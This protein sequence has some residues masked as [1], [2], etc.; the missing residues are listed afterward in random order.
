MFKCCKNGP[1]SLVSSKNSKTSCSSTN[2]ALNAFNVFSLNK[3]QLLLNSPANSIRFQS[4]QVKLA[5]GKDAC[6]VNCYL[7]KKKIMSAQY[8][9][10]E[11]KLAK[12]LTA[13]QTCSFW[14]K[15]ISA[16][17]SECI[18]TVGAL[19]IPDFIWQNQNC[20]GNAFVVVQC[21][22]LR[23]I[24]SCPNTVSSISCITRYQL[25]N[26]CYPNILTQA[27]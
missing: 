11:T 5:F 20:P 6:F 27:I 16:A 21:V 13:R 17:A 10:D 7:M 8:V 24:H 25:F 14:K 19:D 4:Q 15:T 26:K 23:T 12:F 22:L 1:K 3:Q 18:S 2:G 9:I